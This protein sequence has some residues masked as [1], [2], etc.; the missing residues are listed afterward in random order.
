VAII[1]FINFD[2]VTKL[3]E[4]PEQKYGLIGILFVS[5]GIYEKSPSKSDPP[6]GGHPRHS[7]RENF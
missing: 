6:I 3:S 5:F 2:K 1:G 4:D 7:G